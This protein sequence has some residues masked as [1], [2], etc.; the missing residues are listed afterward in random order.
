M[1]LW[2]L[3]GLVFARAAG[4]FA[5]APPTGWR[6]FPVSLRLAVAALVAVPVALVV[7][8]PQPVRMA[9]PQYGA[10]V[11]QEAAIGLLIGLPLWLLIWAAFAAGHLG[12]LAGGF[13]AGDEQQEGP[14]ANLFHV[15]AILFF[16]QLNGHHW[17]I[18]F[19]RSSYGMAPIGAAPGL[20][21]GAAWLYW[22]GLL[23]S[24]MIQLAAPLLLA[25]LL[26]T[27]LVTSL[28]RVLPDLALVHAL[29]AVRA[30]TALLALTVV[31][32]LLG[33]LLLHQINAAA[34]M[35]AAWL[36]AL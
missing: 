11:L 10:A 13:G 16:L 12:D 17:L 2:P 15:T 35:M 30:L 24:N 22:P 29:P 19:L 26:A 18:A 34:G 32:P 31:A 4:V 9:L 5:V 3:W 36:A 28:Q 8:P 21:Q 14:L 1:Q 25:V 7:A 20:T 33:G 27:L 23:F 6:H